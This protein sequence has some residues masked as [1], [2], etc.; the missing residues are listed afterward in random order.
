MFGRRT[1]QQ[2][3]SSNPYEGLRHGALTE[4]APSLSAATSATIQ[5]L[6]VVVDIPRGT[7]YATLVGF[8]DGSTSLYTSTGGG[9]IGA[10]SHAAVA[11]ATGAMLSVVEASADMFPPDDRVDLPPEEYVTIT[12][13][14]RSGR[15]RANVESVAFWGEVPSTIPEIIGAIQDVI[16][17]VSQVSPA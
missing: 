1:P 6:G 9:T 16:T 3:A 10:G 11:E 13:I 4:F 15:R 12:L 14:T 8:A 17:A 2:S 7:G 5:V